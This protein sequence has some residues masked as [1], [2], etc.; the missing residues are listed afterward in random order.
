M[1]YD[2]QYFKAMRSG[3]DNYPLLE[4]DDDLIEYDYSEFSRCEPIEVYDMLHLMVGPPVPDH[5]ELVDFHKLPEPVFSK[6]LKNIL[7]GLDINGIQ[8]FEAQVRHGETVYPDYYLMNVYHEIACLDKVRS[9][10]DYEEEMYFIDKLALDEAVL[11]T[12]PEKHRLIFVLKED[13]QHILYH[14]NVVDAIMAANPK[15]IG[16]ARVDGWHVGSAFD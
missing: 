7:H 4:W 14:Q 16:F 6:R 3:S 8:L 15:G 9:K 2:Q 12:I 13:C 11:D 5:P 1:T 10:Y